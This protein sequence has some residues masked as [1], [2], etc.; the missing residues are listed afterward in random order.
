M[1]GRI[2]F[3]L[4]NRR[5][6]GSCF[7]SLSLATLAQRFSA[8]ASYYHFLAKRDPGWPGYPCNPSRWV[9]HLSYKREDEKIRVYMDRRVTPPRHGY[10]PPCKDNGNVKEHVTPK[11]NSVISQVFCDYSFFVTITCTVR[12]TDYP[13]ATVLK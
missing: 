11:Y 6:H 13:V 8:V 2:L 12:A 1:R 7:F 3:F 9:P 5:S 4:K 10:P